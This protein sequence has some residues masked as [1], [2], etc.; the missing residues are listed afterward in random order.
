MTNT[1]DPP[2]SPDAPAGDAAAPDDAAGPLASPQQSGS[3]DGRYVKAVE[4]EDPR[5][6]DLLHD[7]QTAARLP[8][9]RSVTHPQPSEGQMGTSADVPGDAHSERRD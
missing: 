3:G 7:P 9:E 5:D 8:R 2:G 6:S 4:G 1:P